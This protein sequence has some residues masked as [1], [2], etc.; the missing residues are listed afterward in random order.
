MKNVTALELTSL[1]R[2]AGSSAARSR[3]TAKKNC[4][5]AWTKGI[6]ALVHRRPSGKGSDSSDVF[7]VILLYLVTTTKAYYGTYGRGICV[8]YV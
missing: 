1:K 7:T 6:D 4:A 5:Q 8:I 3:E 2:L